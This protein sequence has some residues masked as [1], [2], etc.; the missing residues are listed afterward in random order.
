M[1]LIYGNAIIQWFQ[2]SKGNNTYWETGQLPDIDFMG[3]PMFVIFDTD[4]YYQSQGGGEDA[5]KPPK[6]YLLKTD[7]VVGAV[8]M[9]ITAMPTTCIQDWIFWRPGCA[10]FSKKAI[11]GAAYQQEG[12][13]PITILFIIPASSVWMMWSTWRRF[14]K[15]H[16]HGLSDLRQ[17]RLDETVG[18]AVRP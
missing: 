2:D 1:K 17:C 6:K 18:T 11:Q 15:A 14:R 8:S 9:I 4:A 16:R 3:K 12:Q 10:V 7:G 13:S 5:P